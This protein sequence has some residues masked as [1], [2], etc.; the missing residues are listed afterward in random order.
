MFQYYWLCHS[1]KGVISYDAGDNQS[2][3]FFADMHHI[4][5]NI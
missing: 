1:F 2:F 4:E 3:C 5:L